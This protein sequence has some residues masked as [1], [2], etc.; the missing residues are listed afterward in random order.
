MATKLLPAAKIG[1]KKKT[2]SAD[3]IRPNYLKK[4]EKPPEASEKSS[5]R[6]ILLG[7]RD[8]ITAKFKRGVSSFTMKRREKQ[9][10]RIEAREKKIEDKEGK[11]K[12]GN[13]IKPPKFVGNIFS[14]ITNFLLFVAGGI[15]F[16]ILGLE[17]SLTAIEKTLEIIGK[18]VEIFANIVGMFTN[19]ID[20][21]V[22]GYDEFLQKI[23]DVT[24]FDKTKI[25]KFMEDFKYV[26]N[27]AIIAGIFALRALPS[28]MRRKCLPNNL[29]NKGP[30]INSNRRNN[31]INNRRTTSGGQQL[32]RGPFSRV[33]E[34]LRNIR[35]RIPFLNSN[36]SKGSNAFTRTLSKLN[37]ANFNVSTGSNAFTRNLSKLNPL[38]KKVT[39]GTGG[40]QGKGLVGFLK[41]IKLPVPRWLTGWKGNALINSIFAYFEFKGRK[42]AG[43]SDLK[44]TSGTTASTAGG[45]AGFF[46][47][48][49]I[50]AGIGAAIGAPFAGVGAGP[51]ALIGGILG[52]IAG[53][54]GGSWLGGSAS[55]AIVDQ[56][57]KPKAE[58]GD[59]SKK[60]IASLMDYADYELELTE[61]TNNIIQPIQV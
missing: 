9:K 18:G 6:E 23:E 26:I 36:V 43:Q 16:N 48:S 1:V 12:L 7:I 54:M 22:K 60:D 14:S 57:E 51:G 47:G 33:R 40:G 44:A 4:E 37:P 38:N 17:K 45:F 53:S 61:I 13:L 2:I 55:D 49:K 3:S 29:R 19:F 42:S 58:V 15:L 56:I 10:E 59:K 41:N 46:A 24:G 20:S 50:G 25:E 35:N 34:S 39:T 21:A 27:G 31:R 32:N 52:G 11:L 28:L 5:N 30:N 8:F